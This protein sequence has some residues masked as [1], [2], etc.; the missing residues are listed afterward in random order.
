[1]LPTDSKAELRMNTVDACGFCKDAGLFTN[2]GTAHGW[3]GRTA[4]ENGRGLWF[5][6]GNGGTS[7]DSGTVDGRRRCPS[8]DILTLA[9]SGATPNVIGAS[10][11]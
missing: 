5:L 2:D 9:R 6:N 8:R 7:M 4:D 1:M 10:K 11:L 3:Q